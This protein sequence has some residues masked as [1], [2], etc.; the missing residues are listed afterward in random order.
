MLCIKCIDYKRWL[1]NSNPCSGQYA[2]LTV[3]LPVHVSILHVSTED[4]SKLEKK[5][6]LHEK[7]LNNSSSTNSGSIIFQKREVDRKVVSFCF[8]N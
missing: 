3:L 4:N 2:R 7:L 5:S 6:L 1:K 8:N